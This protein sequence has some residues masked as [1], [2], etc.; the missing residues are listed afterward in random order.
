MRN[1][2]LFIVLIP[3]VLLILLVFLKS[4]N[5]DSF[6]LDAVQTHKMSLEQSHLLSMQQFREKS[7][8]SVVVLVDLRIENEYKKGSFKDAVNIPFTDILENEELKELKSSGNAIVLFSN[9]LSGSAKALTLLTQ[10]GYSKLFVLDIPSE[11]VSEG[12][13]IKDS[14]VPGNEL[15][16]YKFQ[17]DTSKGLE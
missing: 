15:L 9:S 12:F 6:E 13:T 8:D 14:I 16:K 11:L 1:K 17:P 5:Q 10:M 3:L 7:Q 4:I 2:G